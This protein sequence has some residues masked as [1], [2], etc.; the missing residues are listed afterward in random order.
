MY[1]LQ[2]YLVHLPDPSY[3]MVIQLS[4]THTGLMKILQNN[5]RMWTQ[6]DPLCGE[7]SNAQRIIMLCARLF[8][9]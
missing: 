9:T 1:E 4:R 2:L 7:G 6:G 8:Q 5:V 3:G